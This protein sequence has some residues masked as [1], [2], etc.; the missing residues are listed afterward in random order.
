MI[1]EIRHHFMWHR[2][3]PPPPSAVSKPPTLTRHSAASHLVAFVAS[4]LRSPRS[5]SS[6]SQPAQPFPLVPSFSPSLC[7]NHRSRLQKGGSP[8][9]S[10]SDFSI[11]LSAA[12]VVSDDNMFFS[13]FFSENRSK[14]LRVPTHSSPPNSDGNP[15]LLFSLNLLYQRTLAVAIRLHGGCRRCQLM[16]FHHNGYCPCLRPRNGYCPSLCPRNVYDLDI[17]YVEPPTHPIRLGLALNYFVF[18]YEILNQ[19]DKACSMVKQQPS[20][21]TT[22]NP[23]ITGTPREGLIDRSKVMILLCDNDSKSSEEV[24]TFLIRC[25]Y[26]VVYV[27]SAR[28]VIDALNAERQYIDIILAEVDLPIKKGMNMLKYIAHDKELC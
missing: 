8:S 5:P 24:F 16:E 13:F 19:S 10:L 21:S 3:Q 2:H 1:Q 17:A 6:S 20:R 15:S 25:S 7:L 23:L 18:Y 26:Q 4:S 12:N 22:Y 14:G 28:Q 11:F 27:K 9:I